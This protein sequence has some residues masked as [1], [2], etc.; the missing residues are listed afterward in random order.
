[1]NQRKIIQPVYVSTS[2]LLNL[3]ILSI[4][5]TPIVFYKIITDKKKARSSRLINLGTLFLRNKHKH[6]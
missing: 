4:L 3:S 2:S 1:M 5:T 6:H